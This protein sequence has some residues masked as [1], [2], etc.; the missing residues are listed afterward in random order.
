MKILSRDNATLDEY[1]SSIL[2]AYPF[3]QEDLGDSEAEWLFRSYKSYQ[4]GLSN[5]D[6]INLEA[7][8]ARN[9]LDEIGLEP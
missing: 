6:H 5:L 4:K 2:S 8:R 3:A 9:P 7:G 1:R